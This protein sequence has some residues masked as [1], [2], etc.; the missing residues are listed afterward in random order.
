MTESARRAPARPD[1][2]SA[3]DEEHGQPGVTLR[4]SS[5]LSLYAANTDSQ[6][7]IDQTTAPGLMRQPATLLRS[8]LGICARMLAM[9]SKRFRIGDVADRSAWLP[10][11]RVDSYCDCRAAGLN[12]IRLDCR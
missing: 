8:L 3:W 9:R 5:R 2:A 7:R 11:V 12:V 1:V 4:R 10:V 6:Q